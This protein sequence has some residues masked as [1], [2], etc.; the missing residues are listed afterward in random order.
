MSQQSPIDI[1][2]TVAKEVDNHVELN[3][4]CACG[5]I[6]H[7]GSNFKV[8]WH[9]DETSTLVLKETVYR[10]VQFHFHTPSEHTI[11]GKAYPFCMHLVHASEEGKLA[12]VA[13][14]FE[15][16]DENK[17]LAQVW[18]HLPGLEPKG[19]RVKVDD[20]SFESLDISGENYFRYTGS[21]TT[22]PYTEGVEWVI[23]QEPRQISQEQI[24]DFIK[25]IPGDSNARDL[26][27]VVG[28]KLL[29]CCEN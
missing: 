13:V 19:E 17:F 26:Q 16:G 9:G 20:I 28:G 22:P 15:V 12:V 5:E 29:F 24:D 6:Q 14:F 18:E 21:L 27:P 10:P 25:V 23:I 11:E 3:V 1:V 8:H 4:G 2:P 7:G